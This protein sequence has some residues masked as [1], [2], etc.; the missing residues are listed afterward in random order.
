[1]LT[2]LFRLSLTL[3]VASVAAGW[4]QTAE[5]ACGLGAA[6]R[7]ER[8]EIPGTGRSLTL[9][10]PGS[11][12]P[13]PLVIL[14]HGSG[15]TGA[16][17]LS[18]TT[19]QATAD[20]NGFIV[21]SPDGGIPGGDG[22]VWNIPGV[23]TILGRVPGPED[24]NDVEYLGALVDALIAQ[25]CVDPA[26]VYLTGL[27]GGGRMTSWMACVEPRRFAAIAPVVG[28][29]A[30]NPEPEDPSR[31]DPETC[32]PK[33]P[34]PVI[35]FAGDADRTN[36]TQGGGAPYWSYSMHAA[37]RRWAQLNGCTGPSPTI[38][39]GENVYEERYPACADDA[40]VV[41]RMT[42]GGG[43]FWLADEEAMWAFFSRYSR[44][45]P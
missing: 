7:T 2:F 20:R 9:H 11:A 24:A 34:V 45:E 13:L 17:M 43:H 38:W 8:V 1:M 16:R 39:V 44:A 26:R 4:L 14:L 35:A 31:P 40:Q 33:T 27:S 3:A 22:F 21:A 12:G 37:L 41:A 25:Q 28:L 15:G 18:D 6:G 23:P 30:G 19:L 29:R 36:P 32:T 10:R 5:A 42:V